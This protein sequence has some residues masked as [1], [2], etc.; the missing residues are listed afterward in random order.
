MGFARNGTEEF[1]VEQTVEFSHSSIDPVDGSP[2]LERTKYE[3]RPSIGWFRFFRKHRKSAGR[4][5]KPSPLYVENMPRLAD[6]LP[7]GPY[8]SALDSP[9]AHG[10]LEPY[11]RPPQ[12]CPRGF[13]HRSDTL[14]T[15]CPEDAGDFLARKGIAALQEAVEEREPGPM[16]GYVNVANG[17]HCE[18][19]RWPPSGAGLAVWFCTPKQSGRGL[20]DQVYQ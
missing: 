2:C 1:V 11:A 9:S 17:G 5:C 12:G 16:P 8:G 7:C 19:R 18:V 14:A 13:E 6:A 20:P 3:D 4:P 15:A 10:F